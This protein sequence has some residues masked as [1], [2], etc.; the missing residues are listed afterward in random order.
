MPALEYRTRPH[1]VYRFFDANDELLYIGCSCGFL[2]RMA[3]HNTQATWVN[4]A[5]KITMKRYPDWNSG[6]VAEAAAI[7]NEHP[8]WNDKKHFMA[9]SRCGA[10]KEITGCFCKG[11]RKLY[12]KEK[13]KREKAKKLAEKI[14]ALTE[15]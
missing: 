7:A 15:S 10:P 12:N 14:K 2:N 9:C 4:D 13:Y 8:K 5:V 11:C 3:F 6:R 1:I